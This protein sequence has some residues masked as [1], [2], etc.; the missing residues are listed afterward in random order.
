MAEG[1]IK[2]YD[3]NKGFGFIERGPHEDD[4]WFHAR[5]RSN[6]TDEAQFVAGTRVE[7]TEETVRGRPKACI[8]R[9]LG[10]GAPVPAEP[11]PE[12]PQYTAEEAF[13]GL[14]E[15]QLAVSEWTDI[16]EGLFRPGRA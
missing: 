7:F 11:G 9:I 8:S 3:E 12:V 10:A 15:A 1:T 13:K 16:I 5:D 6:G 2:W 14:R 4:I